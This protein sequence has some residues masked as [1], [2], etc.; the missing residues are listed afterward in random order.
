MIKMRATVNDKNYGKTAIRTIFVS[1]ENGLIMVFSC[2]RYL[3]LLNHGYPMLN[4]GYPMLN[5]IF[6]QKIIY[7]K[8]D[9]HWKV[10]K[11]KKNTK[12]LKKLKRQKYQPLTHFF[13]K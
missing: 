9:L 12:P 11:C 4:H 7:H 1:T 2:F 8:I 5:N 3:N 10:G 13:N 6:F